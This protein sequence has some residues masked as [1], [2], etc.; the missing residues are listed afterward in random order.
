MHSKGHYASVCPAATGTTNLHTTVGNSADEEVDDDNSCDS[1]DDSDSLYGCTFTTNAETGI[2]DTWIL[3]DSQSTVSI[4]RNAKFLRN[5]RN[6]P[7]K[8]VVDTNAGKQISTMI[9]DLKNFGPVWYNPE[10]IANIL[11]HSDVAK[12][13]RITS[14]SAIE[15]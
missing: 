1:G 3:L 10:S 14:D 8:L 7:Q 5:I 9:G 4:F 6:S 2:P 13:Y 11:S 12:Q 15:R